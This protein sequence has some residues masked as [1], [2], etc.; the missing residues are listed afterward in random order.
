MIVAAM[1]FVPGARAESPEAAEL[2]IT[3]TKLDYPIAIPVMTASTTPEQL[4]YG[5]V[6][7]RFGG[8]TSGWSVFGNAAAGAF[9]TLA[10]INA[11]APRWLPKGTARRLNLN[12]T[13]GRSPSDVGIDDYGMGYSSH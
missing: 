6:G 10:V 2:W 4:Y 9:F 3:K 8:E 13:G 11:F 12:G 7:L 1:L 5:G